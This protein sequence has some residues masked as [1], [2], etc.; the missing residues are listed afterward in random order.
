MAQLPGYLKWISGSEA[1]IDERHVRISCARQFE[2]LLFISGYT[3]DLTIA[4]LFER[5]A[6]TL[7][8][9]GLLIN[10]DHSYRFHQIPRSRAARAELPLYCLHFY[11]SIRKFK[12]KHPLLKI[13]VGECSLE[14]D[15]FSKF[16]T[17]ASLYT[18]ITR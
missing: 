14:S 13:E 15:A 1:C 16:P 2:N 12:G 6:Y 5:R 17:I 9:K 11:R 18:Q 8:E 7:A 10:D 4:H 3:D